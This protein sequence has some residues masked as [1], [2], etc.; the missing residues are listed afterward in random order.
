MK[1]KR[2]QKWLRFDKVVSLTTIIAAG[3]AILLSVF[4]ITELTLFEELTLGIL[5]LIAIDALVERV[6]ILERI[7]E[8]VRVEER[9][10]PELQTEHKLLGEHPFDSFIHGAGEV[11]ICGGSMAG[12]IKNE[13]HTLETW[14]GALKDVNG[15]SARENGANLKLLLVDPELV[16]KGRITVQSLFRYFGMNEAHARREYAKDVE[17]TLRAVSELQTAFPGRV[18]VRLTKETPSITMLMVDRH[19][20]RVSI[21]L[22]QNDLK[23]R[24][25]FEIR[26]DDHHDWFDMFDTLYCCRVWDTA[27]QFDYSKPVS[28]AG[29]KKG[30]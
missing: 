16:R 25:I 12:L 24:P 11:F 15:Q 10:G 5:G 29:R 26:K 6:N 20:A 14:L 30:A 19:K 23:N 2:W 3:I 21:N 4:G 13:F 28:P 9:H 7:L 27:A 18:E 22:Y 8:A 17:K 1:Q